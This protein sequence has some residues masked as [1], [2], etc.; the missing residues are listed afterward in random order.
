M[1]HD[2]E[3]P[4]NGL[5]QLGP[6]HDVQREVCMA[7]EAGIPTH[8]R[9]SP[10]THSVALTPCGL[11]SSEGSTPPTSGTKRP[12]FDDEESVAGQQLLASTQDARWEAEA[13]AA[14]GRRRAKMVADAKAS[15][16]LAEEAA[17]APVVSAAGGYQLHLSAKSSSGYLG[18]AM[19]R[20]NRHP[21]LISF[22]ALGPRNGGPAP[23]LGYFK[24]AVDA[25]VAYAKHV[26][27]LER[28]AGEPPPQH[29]VSHEVVSEVVSHRAFEGA[30]SK[31]SCLA[32]VEANAKVSA[33]TEGT[34]VDG[35]PAIAEVQAVP[36]VSEVA[37]EVQTVASEVATEALT[38]ARWHGAS[39][40]RA[41]PLEALRRLM[42]EHDLTVPDIL[43]LCA[44]MVEGS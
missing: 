16:V 5:H 19:Y 15:S 28:R 41:Q 1:Q 27:S 40:E 10:P 43:R 29:V 26:A 34:S 21:A 6:G 17:S 20:D 42:R 30:P 14:A 37:A 18:V 23:T 38:E 13:T 7:E 24:T 3:M 8:T 9:H 35:E 11:M 4:H 36:V 25:A 44:S 2:D 33:P 12:R 32:L 22:K 31:A 39:R